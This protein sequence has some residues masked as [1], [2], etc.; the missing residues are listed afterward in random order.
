MPTTRPG[1][2]RPHAAL[3]VATRGSAALA[4]ADHGPAALA[5][6]ALA[7]ALALAAVVLLVGCQGGDDGAARTGTATSPDGTP[8]AYTI[9]GDGPAVVLVHCWGGARGFW[10]QARDDLARDHRVLAVDL[11]G[12]GDSGQAREDYTMEAFAADVLAAMDAEGLASAV[13]VGHSMGGTVALAV[14]RAAPDR[15]HRIVG[16]DNLHQV[17]R[18]LTPEQLEGFLAPF[19]ADFAGTVPGFVRA[20]YPADADSASVARAV[21]VLAATSPRVG[22][23][24]FEHMFAYDLAAAARA[25]ARPLHLLNDTRYPVAR[26]QWEAQGV[27]VRLTS[28][29]DVGHFPMFSAPE[30]FTARLRETVAE[31]WGS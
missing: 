17:D 7:L 14:A 30:A 15:V 20:M 4:H 25:Y 3:A 29:E 23:S 21:D 9:A 8:I 31:A 5:R 1:T 6:A 18:G 11:G 2:I 16:I 27:E 19:R 10:D 24:A 28:M 13:M 12:H 22:L 26:D